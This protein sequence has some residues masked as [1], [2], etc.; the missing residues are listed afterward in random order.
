MQELLRCWDINLSI[1]YAEMVPVH[2]QR[3]CGESQKS[4]DRKASA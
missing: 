2:H 4:E 1:F 3:C